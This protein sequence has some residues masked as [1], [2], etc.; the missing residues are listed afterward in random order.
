MA[1]KSPAFSF[2]PDSW[3]AGTS[4]MDRATKG[5]YIDLLALSWLHGC[6]TLQQCQRGLFVVPGSDEDTA[7]KQLLRDKFDEKDGQYSNTRLEEERAKQRARKTAGSKGGSKTQAKR[8]QKANQNETNPASKSTSN[9]TSKIKGSDSVSDSVSVSSSESVSDSDSKS[10]A[11]S[12]DEPPSPTATDDWVIPNG[13]DSG[14][15]R[16]ALKAFADMRKS[17]K[18][19]L[20]SRRRFSGQFKDFDDVDHLIY[21]L[22]HATSNDHQGIYTDRRPAESAATV[23]NIPDYGFGADEPVEEGEIIDGQVIANHP[24]LGNSNE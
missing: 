8:K 9:H 15:L 6:L 4:L 13:W 17:I 12:G 22:K 5:L 16:D 1:R 14:T 7:L 19:P 2:Y 23:A 20:K 11:G 18:K 24:L 10:K 3:I 21:A